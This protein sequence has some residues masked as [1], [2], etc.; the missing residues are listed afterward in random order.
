M[1]TT[2]FEFDAVRV[3]LGTSNLTLLP[4]AEHTKGTLPKA[5]VGRTGIVI[6]TGV[7]GGFTDGSFKPKGNT[8]RAEIA[9]IL[10]RLEAAM[11]KSPSDFKALNELVEVAKT[12]TNL[13]TMGGYFFHADKGRTFEALRQE[14]HLTRNGN[15]NVRVN[16]MIVIDTSQKTFKSVYADVFKRQGES[17]VGSTV[18]GRALTVAV[19]H[20]Y[21]PIKSTPNALWYSGISPSHNLLANAMGYNDTR[22]NLPDAFDY[23]K[24]WK[25][26][27]AGEQKMWSATS[28]WEV[29]AGENLFY[30]QHTVSGKSYDMRIDLNK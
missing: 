4:I 11:K 19:E 17:I 15:G 30:L 26:D 9:S 16:R 27:S 20:A 6:G 24:G 3:T 28:V 25:F 29:G 22:Y 23:V 2:N 13:H 21:K 10:M 8:T 18:R 14:K 7:M 1:I 12:G 5:D